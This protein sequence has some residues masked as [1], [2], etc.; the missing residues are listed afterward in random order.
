MTDNKRFLPQHFTVNKD[1]DLY[2]QASEPKEPLQIGNFFPVLSGR[3]KRV[4]SQSHDTH[5]ITF[6][7]MIC[8]QLT[9]ESWTV[10]YLS[11]DKYDYAAKADLRCNSAL[12]PAKMNFYLKQIIN[13]QLKNLENKTMPYYDSLGWT[14]FGGDHAYMAGNK[15]ITKDGI[16]PE[17]QYITAD[18]LNDF[19]FDI[20]DISLQNAVDDVIKIIKV[21]DRI[22]PILIAN[23]FVG[24]SRSLFVDAEVPPQ[25]AVYLVAPSQRGKTTL[26]CLTSSLYNRKTDNQFALSSLISSPVS[27]QKKIC[28]F[29][30]TTYIIDDL[31]PER[32]STA[33]KNREKTFMELMRIIG[34]NKEKQ[35]QLGK[36]TLGYSPNANVVATGEYLPESF[37]TLARCVILH[38]DCEL[39]KPLLN[40]IN[41][42][43][44]SLPT[45]AYHYIRWC[46]EHYEKIVASIRDNHK[47]H[48]KLMECV[49]T[50]YARV[51]ENYFCVKMGMELLLK[52]CNDNQAISQDESDE[53]LKTFKGACSAV[54]QRQRMDMNGI[55][56]SYQIVDAIAWNVTERK[57]KLAQEKQYIPGNY[58]GVIRENTLCFDADRLK[59][60]LKGS[61]EIR[62]LSTQAINKQLIETGLLDTD[63]SACNTKKVFG[64]R[65]IVL[66]RKRLL[67]YIETVK[68]DFLQ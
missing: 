20:E 68:T 24:L 59:D 18:I 1:G 28:Q 10:P 6:R 52:F 32:G 55:K 49:H 47:K 14:T 40:D 56:E 33:A 17:D 62:N 19:H 22:T 45:V 12:Q 23:T 46:A 67:N 16:I 35:R 2:Y 37:S 27:M 15:M 9:D 64:R 4:D 50:S 43:P 51:Y 5:W 65:M 36:E 60:V 34:S 66:N 39:N 11:L 57:F 44:L 26:A 13:F 21:D 54:I 58:D 38:I 30:D 42:R 7:L 25:Y 61:L 48:R 41:E 8:G 63:D 29:R 31:Y 53:I 3:E